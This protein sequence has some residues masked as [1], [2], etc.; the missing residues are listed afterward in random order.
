M[1]PSLK[2]ILDQLY[3]PTP[4]PGD[5]LFLAK[6]LSKVNIHANRRSSPVESLVYINA[7]IPHLAKTA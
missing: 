3:R 1:P 6:C 4:V 5:W 2:T 7:C